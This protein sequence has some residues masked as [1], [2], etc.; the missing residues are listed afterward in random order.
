MTRQLL[1]CFLLFQSEWLQDLAVPPELHW[2]KSANPLPDH[3][4]VRSSAHTWKNTWERIDFLFWKLSV[5]VRCNSVNAVLFGFCEN[6]H[7]FCN[8]HC[9]NKWKI[10]VFDL[11]CRFVWVFQYFSHL[12]YLCGIAIFQTKRP[13]YII[14]KTLKLIRV[15]MNVRCV[16]F[17]VAQLS[18]L[19]HPLYKLL[20]QFKTVKHWL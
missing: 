13:S 19:H 7:C 14:V 18:H 10:L 20:V 15:K 4:W 2:I 9:C 17:Y 8:R 5:N 6:I 1:N 12:L 16:G 11:H 3:D